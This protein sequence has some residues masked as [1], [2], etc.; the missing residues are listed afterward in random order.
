MKEIH[1]FE[2]ISE[3]E[4]L[5]LK[6]RGVYAIHKKTGLEVYHVLNNDVENLF[7]FGFTTP[8]E[9]SNGVAHIIEHTVLCGSKNFPLKDPFLTLDKQS[10]NTFLNAMTYPDK[11]LYPASSIVEADYFNLMSVYGDAVFFPLLDKHAFEQ[12]GHRFEFDENGELTIQG[13]VFNEMMAGYSDFENV[14]YDIASQNL[15][16][17]SIYSYSSGGDP[18]VIPELTYEQFKAFHKKYYHPCNCKIFLCGNI[19]TDKQ[20][21]F[22]DE[23]FLAFFEY[24]QKPKPIQ[25]I[26]R[27]DKPAKVYASGPEKS[28]DD[29]DSENTVLVGWALKETKDVKHL[30][31]AFILQELLIGH[32]GSFLN[33]A[34]LNS[35][36]G[37]LYPYNSL[38]TPYESI[39]F[40][41]GM[42]NVKSGDEEKVEALILETLNSVVSSDIS[43]D[44]IQTALNIIDFSNREVV[45]SGGAPFSLSLMSRAY[46]S[47]NYGGKPEDALRYISVFEEVKKNILKDKNYLKKMITELLIE[48]QH[49]C[50]TVIK[51]DK[52][53]TNNIQASVLSY[54]E[55][56][57]SE[58]TDVKRKQLLED[59]AV[60]EKKKVTADTPE[61]EALIPYLSKNELPPVEALPEKT[62]ECI[63]GIPVV[64]HQQPTNNIAYIDIA[65]PVDCIDDED[66]EYLKL[67]SSSLMDIGTDKLSWSDSLSISARL[68]GGISVNLISAKKNITKIP[69]F[70]KMQNV[71]RSEDILGRD[72][73]M[74][75]VKMLGD[76]V[77][78]ATEFVFDLIKNVSFNDSKRL[79][80]IIKE[81]KNSFENMPAMSGHTFTI[82]STLATV[83]DKWAITERW[84]GITQ[85]NFL[86]KLNNNIKNN[87]HEIDNI[88]KK[89]T[90]IHK[91][92]LASGL[93]LNLTGTS[94]NINMLKKVLPK[95]L[96]GYSGIQPSKKIFRK[97]AVQLSQNEKPA[98]QLIPAN[99]QV[100]HSTI[101]FKS[102]PYSPMLYGKLHVFRKWLSSGPLWERIRTIGGAYGVFSI[103]QSLEDF[104]AVVTYRDP[105]PLKSLNEIINIFE[106]TKDEE[107]TNEG[108][109]KL[110][111]G[112][113]NTEVNPKTPYSK[114]MISFSQILNGVSANEK[115]EEVAGIIS[116]TD[117][118]M[119]RF[120][121][122]FL[123]QAKNHYLV[124]TVIGDENQLK[125]V[126][127]IKHIF[128]NNIITKHI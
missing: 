72:W 103:T 105:N 84:A 114:S 15:F 4:L 17:D 57:K 1:N 74:I 46:D 7:C 68:L 78:E 73:I 71:L 62:V 94:E 60:L 69:Q 59:Q 101:V 49:R 122:F 126:D 79:L 121:D 92:I 40:F 119:K 48:N 30:M 43:D 61:L 25:P 123:Q 112:A 65:I 113:Y 10:I 95:C 104:F 124:A 45:R 58:L 66:Y 52:N 44:K 125:N 75:C 14:A 5:E 82:S 51:H 76:L 115:Q 18:R 97:H 63:S 90:E 31:E 118:D 81:T 12:E 21:K 42:S 22:L 47:W 96:I 50:T 9:S 3:H 37:E 23:K 86:T 24:S 109:E 110:I 20:L 77:F 87:A 117:D 55:K 83:S 127:K 93:L 67:Y 99:I 27:L 35:E 107:F 53:Y 56:F 70:F 89:L 54:I 80:N 120:A 8:P 28:G 13:V 33:K 6:A 100:A 26:V 88:S 128:A 38:A 64:I 16:K 91:K 11:T 98:L 106:T 19:P 2:I 39:A 32:D 102:M 85:L 29:S 36:F 111:V 116:A 34:L 108:I 41:V